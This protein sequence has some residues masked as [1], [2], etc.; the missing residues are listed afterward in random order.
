MNYLEE[1]P[2]SNR[3][4]KRTNTNSLSRKK[5]VRSDS[6][7]NQR[8]IVDENANDIQSNDNEKILERF[9]ET[10]SKEIS[11]II[12]IINFTIAMSR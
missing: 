5:K 7:D 6:T 9:I 10:I 12:Q 11:S 4:R 3:R 1:I 8:T 2:L